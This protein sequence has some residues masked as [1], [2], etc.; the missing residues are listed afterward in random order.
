MERLDHDHKCPLPSHRRKRSQII[1]G[2]DKISPELVVIE[3]FS[4]DIGTWAQV[5]EIGQSG[6]ESWVVLSDP[7]G[8]SSASFSP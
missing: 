4:P 7:K 3:R 6:E 2:S 5:A 8:T 1:P